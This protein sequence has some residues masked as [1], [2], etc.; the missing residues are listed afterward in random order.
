M[1]EARVGGE[2]VLAQPD[3]EAGTVESRQGE[4]E[5][6]EPDIDVDRVLLAWLGLLEPGAVQEV[7]QP[8]QGQGE[9][10]T[11]EAGQQRQ[12]KAHQGDGL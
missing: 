12:Y 10:A 9:G 8:A 11:G 1:H 6:T 4:P 5:Q 2:A 3:Y 7:Q